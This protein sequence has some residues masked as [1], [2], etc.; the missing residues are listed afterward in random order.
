MIRESGHSFGDLNRFRLTI[1]QQD[2]WLKIAKG[3]ARLKE[4][5][6][7]DANGVVV[8]S[9][10]YVVYHN[11]LG[12][13]LG[14]GSRLSRV[15][16]PIVCESLSDEEKIIVLAQLL[17][18]LPNISFGFSIREHTA[19]ARLI[20]QA[21]KYAGFECFEQISYSQPPGDGINRL[22][23][24]LREHIKQARNKLDVISIDSDE[25]INFYRNN[26]K[27][28]SKKSNFS[29]KVARELIDICIKRE[30]SQA[31]IIAASR[32]RPEPPSERRAVDAA[33]CLVWDNECCYYWLSTR[34]KEAHPDAIKLL[35]AEA[36]NHASKLGLIFDADDANTSGSHRLFGTIFRMPNEDKRYVFTY[37]SRLSQLYEAHRCK[38]DK[39][40]TFGQALGLV[41][42]Y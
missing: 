11:V 42:R 18:K 31:R 33:I 27:V 39:I 16:G 13:P 38:I 29:L 21:F 15:S 24:K 14:S 6:V 19:N 23:T 36:M 17:K 28:A 34:H 5:Q 25:F 3:S 41:S 8:G 26:L 10:T 7:H 32:K 12:I 2:W 1:F 40:K 30:P 9:L 20:R 37:T 22:G 4:V 35:V